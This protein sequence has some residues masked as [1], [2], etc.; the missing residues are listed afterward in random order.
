MS[1]LAIA[2]CLALA[3][4]TRADAQGRLTGA[5]AVSAGIIVEAVS[6]GRGMEQVTAGNLESS[7][8]SVSQ[9]LIPVS[10]AVPLSETWALDVGITV[11]HGQVK[12]DSPP[13]NISGNTVSLGGMS[14]VRVRLNGRL[15]DN[16]L[17]TIGGN[18][19]TGSKELTNEETAALGVLAA[20]A[21]G[22]YLPPVSLGPSGTA[23][24]VYSRQIGD[25]GWAAGASYE[26]R[27]QFSPIAALAA[28]LPS[29]EFDPGS[30]MHLSLGTEGVVGRNAL[31]VTLTTDMYTD[32]RLMP[33]GAATAGSA[34]TVQLG[35]MLGADVQ[36]KIAA[37]GFRDLTVYVSEHY[38]GSF[39]RDG[40]MVAGS[41][42]NYLYGGFRAVRPLTPQLD[43]TGNVDAWRHSGLSVDN[44]L[45]TSAATSAAAT[46]GLARRFGV[47]GVE[48]FVRGRIGSLDSG[49]GTGRFTGVTGGLTMQARF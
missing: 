34:A 39:D 41:S 30:A 8:K 28:G 5:S 47:F 49:V 32:E 20:P 18:A 40:S 43:L 15:L 7:I 42:A 22:I 44:S 12:F 37:S 3:P 38:R 45:V 1:A 26:M 13:A 2:S 6:F 31:G 9:W 48:P 36:Y 35:P 19:P 14:D 4:W 27:G 10:A 25:W 16:L 29:P 46:L 23:G 17:L 21:L 33:G 11:S 24:L